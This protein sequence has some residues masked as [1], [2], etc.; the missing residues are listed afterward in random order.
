VYDDASKRFHDS[1]SCTRI[2]AAFLIT[3]FPRW[4][5]TPSITPNLDDPYDGR[6]Y[7]RQTPFRVHDDG[8]GAFE[9]V[10]RKR[11]LENSYEAALDVLKGKTTT[12]PDSIAAR[13]SS[14]PPNPATASSLKP[15]P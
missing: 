5:T 12:V 9:N 4:S 15:G 8:I 3:G 1:D 2:S 7:R 14:S 11:D 6:D 13:A 10:M